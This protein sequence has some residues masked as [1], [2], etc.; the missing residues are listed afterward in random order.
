MFVVQPQ[1]GQRTLDE[2]LLQNQGDNQTCSAKRGLAL[3]RSI[4]AESTVDAERSA[5]K[6]CTFGHQCQ[7]R[8][9]EHKADV[10]T[11][12]DYL[13]VPAKTMALNNA[14][15]GGEREPTEFEFRRAE[16]VGQIGDVS[17]LSRQQANSIGFNRL[18]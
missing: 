7:A 5:Q 9:V 18:P 1:E 3:T 8:E 12:R 6:P 2:R 16:L 15:E 4:S 17:S 11:H 10:S 13:M 14:N